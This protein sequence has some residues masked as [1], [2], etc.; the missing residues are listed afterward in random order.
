MIVTAKLDVDVTI[1]AGCVVV[2][3][4]DPDGEC[5]F[6]EKLGLYDLIA[7]TMEWYQVPGTDQF[8]LNAEDHVDV[9]STRTELADALELVEAVMENAN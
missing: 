5:C 4:Y 8:K 1:E 2:R 3:A 6:T 9:D 7:E